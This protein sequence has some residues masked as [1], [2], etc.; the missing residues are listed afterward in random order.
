MQRRSIVTKSL[1]IDRCRQYVMT[2]K[3]T[4]WF[5]FPTN[6]PLFHLLSSQIVT[7]YYYPAKNISHIT[8]CC[9]FS[10]IDTR[11]FISD[12]LVPIAVWKLWIILC[13]DA[14]MFEINISYIY[15]RICTYIYMYKYTCLYVYIYIYISWIPMS[16]TK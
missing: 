14:S 15:T 8:W 7:F 5:V 12:H 13:I 9:Y 16:Q 2:R 1:K 10:I 6:N 3:H 11:L 4:C